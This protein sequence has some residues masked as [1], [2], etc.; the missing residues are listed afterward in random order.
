ME[1]QHIGHRLF[2]SAAVGE[3]AQIGLRSRRSAVPQV[4]VPHDDIAV[5]GKVTGKVVVARYVFRQAVR[6]LHNAFASPSGWYSR[7]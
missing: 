7:Q 2:P 3:M 4:V 6:D 5:L 1:P